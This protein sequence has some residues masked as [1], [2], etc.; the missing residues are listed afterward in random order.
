[1]GAPEFGPKVPSPCVSVCR[2]DTTNGFCRGCLRT[3]DEITQWPSLTDEE[4]DALWQV[5]WKRKADRKAGKVEWA[6]R[7]DEVG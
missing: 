3:L 7:E 2:I 4:K 1:M 5:L 6:D